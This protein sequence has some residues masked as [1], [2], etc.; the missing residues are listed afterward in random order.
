MASNA[1]PTAKLIKKEYEKVNGTIILVIGPDGE[2]TPAFSYLIKKELKKIGG[3]VNLAGPL[4]RFAEPILDRA[5]LAGASPHSL[6]FAASLIAHFAKEILEHPDRVAELLQTLGHAP[7]S[8]GKVTPLFQDNSDPGLSQWEAARRAKLP[9]KVAPYAEGKRPSE[10]VL[11]YYERAWGAYRDAGVLY[12][13]DIANLGGGDLVRTVSLYCKRHGLDAD[14]V[15]PPPSTQ[16]DKDELA[17][18][19]PNSRDAKFLRRRV[20]QR[21]SQRKQRITPT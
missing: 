11:D 9:S 13:D 6:Y 10:T 12:R 18:L 1:N 3:D 20:S 21:E 5:T 8:G 16:R 7:A 14:A 4:Q 15:L 17:T 19:D 2:K